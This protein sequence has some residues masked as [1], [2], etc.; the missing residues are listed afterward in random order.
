MLERQSAVAL[1]VLGSGAACFVVV[2]RFE[3]LPLGHRT[4]VPELVAVDLRCQLCGSNDVTDISYL[5]ATVK[6][7]AKAMKPALLAIAEEESRALWANAKTGEVFAPYDGGVDV[8]VSSSKRR[9]RLEG[10]FAE[11]LSLRSDRL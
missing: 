2:P 9:A 4:S 8:V 3:R 7:D 5:V 6:W 1:E 10:Q 11:W